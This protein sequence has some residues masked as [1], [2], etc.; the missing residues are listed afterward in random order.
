M[1]CDSQRSQDGSCDTASAFSEQHS[2]FVV[3][4]RALGKQVTVFLHAVE[5]LFKRMQFEHA[6][7]QD[8]ALAFIG[9]S[10]VVPVLAICPSTIDAQASRLKAAI[11]SDKY[12]VAYFV[13]AHCRLWIRKLCGICTANA[14]DSHGGDVLCW[15]Q[16][17]S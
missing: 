16:L 12:D 7:V 11:G 15:N 9:I 4:R 10:K 6:T 2:V 8:K 1:D 3:C 17:G 5:E 13:V 14:T